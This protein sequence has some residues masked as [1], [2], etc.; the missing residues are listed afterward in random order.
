MQQARVLVRAGRAVVAV[1]DRTP[2]LTVLSLG[3][4]VQSSTLLLMA[5]HGEI[6]RPD[7]AIFA[8]TGWEP[9]AVYEHLDWIAEQAAAAGIPVE[10]VSV[11][12][13]RAD[14]LRGSPPSRKS[15]RRFVT[16]PL[17]S[18]NEQG[19]PS[20]L[21]RQCTT[22]YKVRPIY[23]RLRE[24]GATAQSP[25]ELWLGI[26]LDEVTRMKP[27]HVRYVINRWPLI[28]RRMTRHD[29]LLWLERHGYD[30][31]PKSS[32][33]GCPYHDDRWWRELRDTSPDEWQD[34]VEFDRAIR[35][36]A[37]IE[38]PVYLH[39]SRLP[40]DEVDLSTPQERGQLG[41]FDEE[42]EGFCGL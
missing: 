5:V 22:E 10:R 8:D 34:A 37:G 29:C 40:L 20:M 36:R 15:G 32:C 12:N 30:R 23:R 1:S 42:C 7:L 39:R 2:R 26:T 9:R 28:E 27:A 3:A 14:M 24:L 21:R 11:G 19:R 25:V 13:I 4:G 41:L 35:H 16:M 18:R 38:Q 17:Y 33:I 6:A 31:P